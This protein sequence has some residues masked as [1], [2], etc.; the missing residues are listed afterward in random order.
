MSRLQALLDFFRAADAGGS[1]LS[2]ASK[3]IE[4]ELFIHYALNHIIAPPFRIG[5]GDITD[6]TNQRSGQ[7]DIVIEYGNSISFPLLYAVNT[8]RLYLA[9]GVCAV[10][11]V[12]SDLA[13]QW[14]EVLNTQSRLT[15]LRR[16]CIDW[17]SYKKQSDS[18]PLF[19]IGYRGWKTME[20]LRDKLDQSNLEG[21]LVLESGLFCG[22]K[23]QEKGPEALYAFFMTMQE[24]TGNLIHAFSDYDAYVFNT[25]MMGISVAKS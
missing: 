3:G 21:I 10:L 16:S 12:K 25:E 22:R 15:P 14:S 2:S 19:A 1:T 9:E 13:G 24:L 4:R 5:T 20:T 7:L 18:I 8:P 6:L 17:L 23:Y 11:E